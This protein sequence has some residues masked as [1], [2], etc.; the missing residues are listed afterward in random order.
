MPENQCG[1]CEASISGGH[2]LPGVVPA[3]VLVR[4]CS[5]SAVMFICMR[6]HHTLGWLCHLG[7]VHV[8]ADHL[9]ASHGERVGLSC[10][11]VR[12]ASV[13]S[14]ARRG[15]STGCL[16]RNVRAAR[17]AAVR[18]LLSVDMTE[19]FTCPEPHLTLSSSSSP[20]AARGLSLR[21]RAH[22]PAHTYTRNE[23]ASM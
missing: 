4:G 1:G 6:H 17:H 5:P 16:L 2:A 11:Q 9:N 14:S 19:L 22:R 13:Q 12:R 18:Q 20:V 10:I 23:R 8:V 21:L 3:R 15:P 7:A